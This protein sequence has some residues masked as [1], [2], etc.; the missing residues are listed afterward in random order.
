MKTTRAGIATNHETKINNFCV[1]LLTTPIP[2]I[3]NVDKKER[4][5]ARQ[6]DVVWKWD[7]FCG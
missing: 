3:F 1:T 4:K 6:K 5:E 2:F 7:C